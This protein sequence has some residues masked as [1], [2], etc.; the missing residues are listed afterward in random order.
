ML[1]VFEETRTQTLG[2]TNSS[3]K[4]PWGFNCL[5][6]FLPRGGDFQRGGPFGRERATSHRE[7]V[8]HVSEGQWARTLGDTNRQACSQGRHRISRTS[9]HRSA[10]IFFACGIPSSEVLTEGNGWVCSRGFGS[11]YRSRSGEKS[12][13]FSLVTQT[14][15]A[16]SRWGCLASAV[17]NSETKS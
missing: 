6:G 17:L 8:A 5:K 13:S 15:E 2:D 4:L 1:S 11:L 7:N 9:Y 12:S 10:W 3:K 16:S 14:L